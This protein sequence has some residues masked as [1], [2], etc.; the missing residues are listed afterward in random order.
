MIKKKIKIKW[1]T[2]V[3]L[4]IVITILAILWTI[5]FMSYWSI[6]WNARDSKRLT[7]LSMLDNGLTLSLS[8]IWILPEVEDESWIL[9]IWEDERIIARRWV[10]WENT[11]R[12]LKFSDIPLDPLTKEKFVYVRSENWMFY[13]VS[14]YWENSKYANS[15]F[16]L[17]KTYANEENKI[18][19]RK[20]NFGCIYFSWE[21]GVVLPNLTFS[22]NWNI[23]NDDNNFNNEIKFADW[24]RF[25]NIKHTSLY[26]K[27]NNNDLAIKLIWW[28][29]K[30][31]IWN[32]EV[33]EKIWCIKELEKR[34]FLD[35]DSW[36]GW[37]WEWELWTW[38][39]SFHNIYYDEDLT[40]KDIIY[41]QSQNLIIAWWSI[42][43]WWGFSQLRPIILS[44]CLSSIA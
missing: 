16:I 44:L 18:I 9:K 1:F 24:W 37:G 13:E 14:I 26:K 12:A 41:N 15:N 30:D 35:E 40:I 21:K 20:W 10:V 22:W 38:Q 11:S 6:T 2:L 8:Q 32:K 33:F 34:W 39:L 31:D 28:F 7:E 23:L 27:I 19:F 29:T 25:V 43:T 5:A 42:Q 36:W 3:E 17:N 4:I